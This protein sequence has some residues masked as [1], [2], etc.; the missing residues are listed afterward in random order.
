MKNV[1]SCRCVQNI[2]FSPSYLLSDLGLD[3]A[4]NTRITDAKEATGR[5][6]GSEPVTAS[7]PL[8]Q[9]LEMDLQVNG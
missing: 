1:C 9:R 7:Q 2:R 3:S 6:A 5:C 4:G 8:Y